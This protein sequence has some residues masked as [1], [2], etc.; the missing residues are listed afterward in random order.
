MY[1]Q[2]PHTSSV[3]LILR[4]LYAFT[5]FRV[6]TATMKS[7]AGFRNTILKQGTGASKKE[8]KTWV[9]SNYV[10]DKVVKYNGYYNIRTNFLA[11]YDQWHSLV[12]WFSLTVSFLIIFLVMR[13][14]SFEFSVF[15]LE[16]IALGSI[17]TL[18]TIFV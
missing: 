17:Q 14:L 4:D 8:P 6:S 12:S 18:L 1:S 15:L 10:W 16:W 5:N 13:T 7:D 3:F 2:A 11:S 9:S